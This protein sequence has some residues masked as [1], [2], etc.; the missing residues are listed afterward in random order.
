MSTC[1]VRLCAC[2]AVC[3]YRRSSIFTVLALV[4]SR[5]MPVVKFVKENKEIEVPEG[6]NLRQ[7]AI[8]AGINV[9]QGVNGFGASINRFMNCK[10][11]GQCGTC[12][13]LVTKGMENTNEMG[14]GEA[15][16]LKYPIPTPMAPLALD[17]LPAMA[18]VGF[19]ETMRLSC[20]T[21]V[22]GDIEVETG[23]ELNLFGENF[24]S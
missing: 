5:F 24:F 4:G 1:G 3:K 14:A 16:R 9:H 8:K 13:V 11:L 22:N 20:K 18:Y 21:T 17:P 15:A 7:E 23:P 19:E 10:G 12:R 2:S 6:A